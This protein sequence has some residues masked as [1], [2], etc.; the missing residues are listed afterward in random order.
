MEMPPGKYTFYRRRKTASGGL[1]YGIQIGWTEA[2]S[3][4]LYY[5]KIAFHSR[6]N[7]GF[8]NSHALKSNEDE[9]NSDVGNEGD[10][11]STGRRIS[12]ATESEAGAQ[13]P[14]GVVLFLRGR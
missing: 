12:P 9:T 10:T 6:L 14:S 5:S 2:Q 7:K 1:R 4:K 13:T 3:N 11:A 8:I